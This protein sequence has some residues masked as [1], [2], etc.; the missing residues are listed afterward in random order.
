MFSKISIISI[1]KTPREFLNSESHFVKMIKSKIEFI[2][3]KNESTGSKNEIIKRESDKILSKI[4]DNSFNIILDIDGEN[5]PSEKFAEILN[6]TSMK[7]KTINFVIGGSYGLSDDVKK[8]A[9][10][11]MSLSKLT[12]PHILAKICLIEQIYRAETIISGKTY[13][14]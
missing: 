1:G 11:K 9:D 2:I 4:K 13:H 8:K 7:G 5:I 10:F 6:S 14:K 12:Y 3:L